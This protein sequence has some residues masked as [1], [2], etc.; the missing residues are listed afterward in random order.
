VMQGDVNLLELQ[1]EFDVIFANINKNILKAH[2]K[3]YSKKLK[4]D[5]KLFLSGF[6]KTDV[7]E[8]T[9]VAE[10][11]G[12]KLKSCNSKNEWAMMVLEKI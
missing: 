7:D 11:Q 9:S 3:T 2:M 1:N 10:T 6:F 4:N 12:L 5:G 8:L